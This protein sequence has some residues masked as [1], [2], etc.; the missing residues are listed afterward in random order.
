MTRQ[1]IQALIDAKIKG[2]GTAV[3]AGSVLPAILTG[4]LDLIEQGGGGGTSDAVQYIPQELTESQQMQARKNQG[5][6]Y[7]EGTPAGT[8]TWD[9]NTEGLESIDLG[10]LLA[11]KVANSP[12]DIPQDA[13]IGC[14]TT[15]QLETTPF[16]QI[17]EYG[18]MVSFVEGKLLIGV[19]GDGFGVLVADQFSVT[20]EGTTLEADGIYFTTNVR[21]FSYASYDSEIHH[22]E[23]KYIKDMYYEESGIGEKTVESIADTYP[24]AAFY[25][26]YI[27]FYKAASDTPAIADIIK[28]NNN[29]IE[30]GDLTAENEGDYTIYTPSGATE[31]QGKFIVVYE[32]TTIGSYDVEPGLYYPSDDVIFSRPYLTSVTYI[33]DISIVHQIPEKYIPDMPS[34]GAPAVK[35][36]IPSM[37]DD[38][39]YN[40]AQ[41]VIHQSVPSRDIV[42]S[43]EGR[44][45][46]S[47]Y[48]SDV[49]N[50]GGNGDTGD[51]YTF[52]S[53]GLYY[54]QVELDYEE[55]LPSYMCAMVY[56][57]ATNQ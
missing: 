52:S 30:D 39:Y 48:V 49:I 23:P 47:V 54:V 34:G 55:G 19:I 16:A 3:D 12:K 35:M 10:G 24:A 45:V 8:I 6:Y 22:I 26:D 14:T 29:T 44:T 15:E 46:L 57:E 11:Y 9:G 7:S 25:Y 38:V 31:T 2:Q 33:G 27:G 18:Q 40:M 43:V 32:S 51:T 41:I 42:F 37:G 53:G 17:V 13:F 28:V 36:T 50:G 56:V 5:L 1:E 21:S 4:I 20:A